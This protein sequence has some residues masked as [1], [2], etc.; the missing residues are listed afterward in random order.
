MNSTRFSNLRRKL[1]KTQKEMALLLGVSI[2]AVHSYEQGWRNVPAY[3]ERQLYFLISRKKGFHEKLKMCWEIKR[4]PDS[5]KNKCPAWEFK[6]GDLCWFIN[7]S[8]CKGTIH[9]DWKAKMT[10]CRSCEVF[11]SMMKTAGHE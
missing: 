7:G 10:I 4:C 11:T 2:K 9:M 3:I 5:R 1:N 6:T 8:I